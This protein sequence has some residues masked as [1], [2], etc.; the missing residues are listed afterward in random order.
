[1]T[2]ERAVYLVPAFPGFAVSVPCDRDGKVRADACT[3]EEL[4]RFHRMEAGAFGPVL[5]PYFMPEP[6]SW[7]NNPSPR[8]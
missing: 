3:P 7:P 5:G 1:M 6:L 4:A 2:P 8:T